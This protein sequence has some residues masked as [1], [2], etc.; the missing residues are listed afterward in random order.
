MRI[1]WVVA[2]TFFLAVGVAG[3]V[4]PILPGTVF[5]FAASACYLRGSERLHA[6]LVNH[7]VLGRHVRVMAGEER[8]P[9]AAKVAAT[10]TM[11][12]AV[13]VSVLSTDVLPLQV[14]LAAVAAVGTWFIV[15]RR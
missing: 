11:W 9:P 6:W 5:L 15:A 1:L 12:I 10:A 14:A 2:G 13:A 3:V 8:M 7:R 4:L